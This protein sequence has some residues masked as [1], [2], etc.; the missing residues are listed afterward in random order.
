MDGDVLKIII[1]SG[2]ACFVMGG[3]ELLLLEDELPEAWRGRVAVEAA[4]CLGFC[5]DRSCGRAPF[6]EVGGEGLA[7]ATMPA[8]LAL[9]GRKLGEKSGD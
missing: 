6:V 8:L 7:S 9:I 2:T 3:S 4:P 1:C 5:K